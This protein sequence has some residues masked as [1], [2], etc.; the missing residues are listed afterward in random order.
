VF[1]NLDGITMTYNKKRSHGFIYGEEFELENEDEAFDE[2]VYIASVISVNYFLIADELSKL[3]D[4]NSGLAIDVGSGLGDLALAVAKRY[5]QLKVQGIDIS[6][7]A[8][9]EANNRAKNENLTNV[10]FKFG[11]IHKLP[12]EDNSIDLVVSH[13]VIHHLIDPAKALSE[14]YRILKP[15]AIAYLTD[16]RRDAPEEIVKEIADS[17]SENQ[18]RGF[19]NS[20]KAA[21]VPEELIEIIVNLGITDFCVA[22]QSFSRE[23]I[24]KNKDRL[25][26]SSMRKADYTKLSLT[27]IIRKDSNIQ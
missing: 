1:T 19:I 5:P 8:I 22:G 21:Y 6:E 10:D 27:A 3:G 2:Y 12:F 18:A 15:G 11:N 4:F 25:R 17:L 16:L 23:T 9:E 13:G 7:K 14:I 20:I 26:N 24:I